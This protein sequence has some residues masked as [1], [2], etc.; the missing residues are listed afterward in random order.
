MY[1]NTLALTCD[2]AMDLGAILQ[3]NGNRLMAELHQKPEGWARVQSVNIF[4]STIKVVW[5]LNLNTDLWVKYCPNI[6]LIVS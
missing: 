6:E 1:K 5:I 2:G 3:F 4:P